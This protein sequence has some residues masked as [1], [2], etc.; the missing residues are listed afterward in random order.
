M[1]DFGKLVRVTVKTIVKGGRADRVFVDID[2]FVTEQLPYQSAAGAYIRLQK[3][4][5]DFDTA[6][7]VV[8]DDGNLL[9]CD[10][11]D[12]EQTYTLSDNGKVI[13]RQLETTLAHTVKQ[14]SY[15]CALR[16]LGERKTARE[17]F[18]DIVKT[19][20]GFEV[21]C[22]VSGGDVTLLSFT[23]YAP[24]YEQAEVIKKNFLSYPATVY[25]TMLGLMTKDTEA[26]GEALEEVYATPY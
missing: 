19:E 4:V 12:G 7:L 24:A 5:V 10:L 14:K 16:L 2:T 17:N 8:V 23:L 26:V 20:S 21:N 18:V 13:A 9:P 3:R 11:T 22:R 25:K 15:D 1:I 6:E